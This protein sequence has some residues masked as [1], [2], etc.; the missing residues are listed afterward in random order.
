MHYSHLDLVIFPVYQDACLYLG[1]MLGAE[2]E[3]YHVHKKEATKH[4]GKLKKH[5]YPFSSCKNAQEIALL[6]PRTA[7]GH[8][9]PRHAKVGQN[10]GS[11]WSEVAEVMVVANPSEGG[12]YQTTHVQTC[13][14]Q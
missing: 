8:K 12:P 14:T 3:T 9:W 13:H 6:A 11:N 10:I 7:N 5:S 1:W 2:T 4:V